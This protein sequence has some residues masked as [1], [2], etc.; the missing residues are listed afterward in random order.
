MIVGGGPA[1]RGAGASGAEETAAGPADLI[2]QLC[3]SFHKTVKSRVNPARIDEIVGVAPAR[4]ALDASS[5]AEADGHLVVLDDHRHR[6]SSLAE[7]EHA[8][9]LLRVLFDVDVF[10]R[11]MPPLIVVT[12]GLRVGSGVFAE[13]VDHA[14]I[15]ATY[16]GPGSA[17]NRGRTP[18]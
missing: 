16:R 1:A 4:G 10:K 6:A 11:H 8:L 2:P 3:E 7:A 5:A 12:G 9:E 17:G 13:D 14:P 15:V 18:V